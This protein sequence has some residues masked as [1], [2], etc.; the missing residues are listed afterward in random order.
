MGKSTMIPTPTSNWLIVDFP[1]RHRPGCGW[2]N[3]AVAK[4]E[5]LCYRSTLAPNLDCAQ[6]SIARDEALYI[7]YVLALREGDEGQAWT[8]RGA[9]AGC[10]RGGSGGNLPSRGAEVYVQGGG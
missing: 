8:A 6:Y 7:P 2:R 1:N 10:E 9:E 3:G 4:E 5:A